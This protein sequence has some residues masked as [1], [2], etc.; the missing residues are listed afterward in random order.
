V[1]VDLPGILRH[2]TGIM[3]G[4]TPRCR[5]EAMEA[6]LREDAERRRVLDAVAARAKRALVVSEGLLVYLEAEA[7]AG[8]AEALHGVQ[9]LRWWLTDLASPRLLQMMHRHW[10]KN[11]DRGDASFRFAP[12]EGSGFFEPHGWRELEW[13][14]TWDESER[15]DRQMRLAWLW[16]F[17]MRFRGAKAKEEIRRFSGYLLLERIS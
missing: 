8:L 3:E 13:R 15:L 4:Q 12:E 1:D 9:A 17:L 11:A 7:V 5:Y 6:D 14:S 2:K 16:R 10:G